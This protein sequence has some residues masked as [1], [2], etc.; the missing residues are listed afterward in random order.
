MGILFA[1]A[2]GLYLHRCEEEEI[3]KENEKRKVKFRKWHLTIGKICIDIRPV[4]ISL[5]VIEIII[6]FM[7]VTWAYYIGSVLEFLFVLE[8]LI[9]VGLVLQGLK[10]KIRYNF[11]RIELDK[12]VNLNKPILKFRGLIAII[13][14]FML[15]WSSIAPTVFPDGVNNTLYRRLNDSKNQVTGDNERTLDD[16]EEVRVISW[17]LATEYI[18][19]AYGETAA[20][21]STD[22]YDLATNTDPSY[23]NGK[24]VWI[25]VPLYQYA[26]WM[27]EKK[28]PFFVYVE[29]LPSNMSRENPD[30]VHRVN[31]EISVHQERIE[32]KW[33]LYQPL[34]DQYAGELEVVQIRFDMD[35]S[36][37][38]YFVVYLGER[39]VVNN[40]VEL[41][42]ILIVD[43]TNL[44]R[45]WE[46]AVTDSSIPSWLE[47]VYPDWY[48]YD[49]VSFWG[50]NRLGL[51]HQ[52]FNKQ[53][54]YVPDDTSARFLVINKT[55]YWQV[56]LLQMDSSVLGGYVTVNTRTGE[57][58]FY[59]RESRSYC[60]WMTA[61]TQIQKY[62]SSGIVGYQELD[63]DEGYLYPIR[64]NDG[65]TRD[66]YIFPLYAG[67]TIQK[68]AILDAQEYTSQPF[69]ADSLSAVL[70]EYKS[71]SYVRNITISGNL[72]W[73][74][75]NL[76]NGYV[77]A[78]ECVV[79]LNGTT[80]VVTKSDLSGGLI[81]DG[82]NEW[83]ELKLAIADRN[84]EIWIVRS[85]NKILDVDWGNATLVT[86]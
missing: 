81:Q 41:K 13:I 71:H 55:T 50:Q 2:L 5:I 12:M 64:M 30:V 85:G 74:L 27:G 43:A 16:P 46:Y 14:L 53:H 80:Y 69:I 45:R 21:Y 19:R 63:I 18:H 57:V 61:Y 23:V 62:L 22:P 70:N 4:I 33:R 11:K 7:D 67:F 29:N 48:V 37:N 15:I 56:P 66:A 28:I 75:M 26:K 51:W 34:F 60:D 78:S 84:T 39:Q 8:I 6:L 36:Y 58:T 73:E 20:M 17:R 9:I 49:W 32:W 44:D 54:L 79:T 25:N 83:R 1:L 76:E 24:F 35:D 59:N 65:T 40:I 77:D 52:W 68:Y 3:D 72:S 42:K 38:P 47:V 10:G 82:D 86:H 31:K